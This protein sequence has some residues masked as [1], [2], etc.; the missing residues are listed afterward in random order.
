MFF[1]ARFKIQVGLMAIL[2]SAQAAQAVNYVVTSVSNFESGN[3]NQ[4]LEQAS[5]TPGPHTITFDPAILPAT[6]EF[7]TEVGGT[8]Y[9]P[10]NFGIRVE[11]NTVGRKMINYD[12]TMTGQGADR[13][14]L[15]FGGF[16]TGFEISAGRTVVFS[17][18]KFANAR[19]VGGDGDF[20]SFSAQ[21]TPGG[22]G[23]GGA[24]RNL[25]N[26]TVT[27]CVFDS[28]RA[29]GGEGG[30]GAFNNNQQGQPAGAACGGAI[31]SNGTSLTV[32]GCLFIANDA[33]GGNIGVTRSLND[34]QR[35]VWIATFSDKSTALMTTEM[36]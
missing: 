31:F 22:S 15:N 14:T 7:N 9:G 20:G 29:R 34:S 26:L 8:A 25:G 11:F 23:E 19:V 13:V 12:L 30:A 4:V 18:I 27:N 2:M 24:I 1:N 21:P 28:C 17:G 3:I 6:F 5:A 16:S 32:T 36:P 33:T 10:S 35:V